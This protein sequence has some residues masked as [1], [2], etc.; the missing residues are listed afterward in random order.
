MLKHEA[1]GQHMM[2]PPGLMRYSQT[3]RDTNPRIK[4]RRAS[5]REGDA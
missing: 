4:S 5:M 2:T 1:H 3:I